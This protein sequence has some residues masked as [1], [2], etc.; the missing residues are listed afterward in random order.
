M[1]KPTLL[2]SLL[3]SL[4]ILTVTIYSLDAPSKISLSIQITNEIDWSFSTRTFETDYNDDGISDIISTFTKI[5]DRTIEIYVNDTRETGA[6]KWASAICN[7]SNVDEIE[8]FEYNPSTEV[9]SSTGNLNYDT[10]W[11]LPDDWC[12]NHEGF[13]LFGAGSGDKRYR[14][15]LPEG[16]EEFTI[17]AGK[18][19]EETIIEYQSISLVNYQYLTFEINSTL[20]RCDDNRANCGIAYPDVLIIDAENVKFGA[21]DNGV[22]NDTEYRYTFYSTKEIKQDSLGYYIEGQTIYQGIPITKLS[23]RVRINT[24]DICYSKANFTADCSYN[25]TNVIINENITHYNLEVYFTGEFNSTGNN[26]MFID[27]SYTISEFQTSESIDTNVRQENNFTH[28]EISDVAPYDSLVLYMP[29]DVENISTSVYDWSKEDNDGTIGGNP[30]WNS[31]GKYG[32]AYEFD[33]V[34]D[35]VDVNKNSYDLGIRDNATYCGW[36][37]PNSN[38]TAVLISDYEASKGMNLRVQDPHSIEFYVYPNNHRVTTGNIVNI[39]SWNLLCGVINSSDALVYHNGIFIDSSTLGEDIGDSSSTLKIG[40]RGDLGSAEWF[41]GSIDEVMIF[42]TSL[43]AQ[44]ILDIYN[45]QSSRF[46]TPGT[47]ELKQFNAT[48][49][50]GWF[51]WTEDS[52]QYFGSDLQKRVGEW[53]VSDGYNDTLSIV[54]G[55]ANFGLVGYYHFDNLS[56]Y[57]E[58]DTHVYDY[59]GNGNNGTFNGTM[60]GLGIYSG[61]GEFDGVDDVVN[62]NYDLL[63]SSGNFTYLAWIKTDIDGIGHVNYEEMARI[64][65]D[66]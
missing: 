55:E 59:S 39:G 27:P 26:T 9:W 13:S 48:F 54:D 50:Q 47:Q 43:T 57:G 31:S 45:N 10:L 4:F 1:K 38:G 12:N 17:F 6:Y 34:G 19:S 5:D 41:N 36:V 16:E 18:G 65:L 42:N 37:R 60:G 14:I 44:Q 3:L 49:E 23:E 32:G 53:E 7:I 15:K 35:Y 8:K 61:A 46:K 25:L 22:N 30:V 64:I 29:F 11:G 63:D 62:V 2:I 21:E 58:N 66:M 56:A 33:G 51:K 24:E 20:E 28:L 52:E 40:E